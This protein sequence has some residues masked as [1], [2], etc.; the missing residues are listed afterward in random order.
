ML[1]PS[2]SHPQTLTHKTHTLL[3]SQI[4]EE[5]SKRRRW[6][7]HVEHRNS[8]TDGAANLNRILRTPILQLPPVRPLPPGAEPYPRRPLRPHR[9]PPSL[10]QIHPLL[11]LRR[12]LRA[13]LGDRQKP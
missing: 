6:D 2:H 12:L 7:S 10:L 13:L 8:T 9:A 11:L 3:T 5:P 1:L 4:E